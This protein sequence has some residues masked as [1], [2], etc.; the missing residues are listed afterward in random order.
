MNKTCRIIVFGTL[1]AA[2]IASTTA[3]G[4][5][6][7]VNVS[8]LNVVRGT[9][10]TGGFSDHRPY[11]C[12]GSILVT[13]T[14]TSSYSGKTS[15]LYKFVR[16]ADGR[17]YEGPVKSLAFSGPGSRTVTD[18]YQFGIGRYPSYDER[19]TYQLVVISPAVVRS[20]VSSGILRCYEG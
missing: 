18:S 9:W 3:L 10:G 19:Y 14:I 11:S 7:T 8:A 17:P 4:M 6:E 5:V 1:G 15:V 16:S 12:P 20:G 2:F 13:G